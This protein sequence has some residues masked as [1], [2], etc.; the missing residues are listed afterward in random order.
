MD[1]E[2]EFD[3]EKEVAYWRDVAIRDMQ[4]AGRLIEY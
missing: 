1:E 2:Q 4:F 3:I